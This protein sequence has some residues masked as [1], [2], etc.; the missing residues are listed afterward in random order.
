MKK[1]VFCFIL[2]CLSLILT[3]CGKELKVKEKLDF[4]INST[5][6]MVDLIIPDDEIKIVNGE[7]LIDTTVLGNKEVVIKYYVGKSEK[8]MSVNIKIIDTI[9]PVIEVKNNK[10]SVTKG[11]ST[12]LLNGVKVKDNSNEEIKAMV[13]G[14]YDFN[15]VGEYKLKY[16][17]E[18]SSGNKAEKDF[19]LVVKNV[20]IKTSGYYVHKEK[21]Y[22][23]GAAFR[24][25]N[26]V[27]FD[28][29]YCPQATLEGFGCG[30]YSTVGTYKINNNKITVTLSIAYTDTGTDKSVKGSKI[31]CT[32]SSE[33]KIV[34][35]GKTMTWAKKFF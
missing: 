3:S 34:C 10:I 18:D 27:T 30:G 26:K 22:W 12:D 5:V 35:S 31:N 11:K 17:A 7:D 33:S 8:Y 1:L 9:S 28:Y 25:N 32:I 13:E 6:K 19:S 20:T 16:V 23:V 2:L 21:E 14:E 15:K 29:N 4:E 24:S